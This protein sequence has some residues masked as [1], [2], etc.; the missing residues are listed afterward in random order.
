MCQVGCFLLQEIENP[1]QNGPNS[2]GVQSK[3]APGLIIQKHNGISRTQVW[4]MFPLCH[5]YVNAPYTHKMDN[6]VLVILSLNKH[7]PF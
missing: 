5:P 1:A 6:Q 3:G 4:P 7:L 2:Q